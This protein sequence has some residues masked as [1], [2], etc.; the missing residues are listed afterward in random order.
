MYSSISIKKILVFYLGNSISFMYWLHIMFGLLLSRFKFNPLLD[1]SSDGF[2]GSLYVLHSLFV[3]LAMFVTLQLVPIYLFLTM[4]C[5]T[6]SLPV[7]R[8]GMVFRFWKPCF[9]RSFWKTCLF[10]WYIY[11]VLVLTMNISVN[12]I[13]VVLTLRIYLPLP[14]L[15]SR[16]GD[17]MSS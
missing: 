15:W 7:S 13:D 3:V 9:R 2:W 12:T 1:E 11:V 10:L 16:I 8:F 5:T 17:T 6:L 14:C 4:C